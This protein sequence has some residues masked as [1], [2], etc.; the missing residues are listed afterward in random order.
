M[1]DIDDNFEMNENNEQKYQ[2]DNF[3]DMEGSPMSNTE[4]SD[5]VISEI[6]EEVLESEI[7]TDD[8]KI[9]E[10]VIDEPEEMHGG[11]TD[12]FNT[13]EIQSI[14][15]NADNMQELQSEAE[16]I[17]H[18][19]ITDEETQN[20][21]EGFEGIRASEYQKMRERAADKAA[22]KAEKKAKKSGRKNGGKL[23]VKAASFVLCAVLLG[24]ISAGAFMGVIHAT[25][26]DDKLEAAINAADKN[27]E[28]H[29]NSVSVN[30]TIATGTAEGTANVAAIFKNTIPSVVSI[31]SKVVYESQG[32]G[33]FG[34][35]G[36]YESTGAGSG[37]IVSKNDSEL[38]IVTN[39]HVIDNASSLIISFVDGKEAPATV[40]GT[41]EENDLAVVA[42]KLS[43]I[44][45]STLNSISLAAFGDSDTLEV[46]DQ[47]IA[48]GNA[49]GYGQS[50]TVGYV[51]ALSR[52]VTIDGVTRTLLQTDAAINPGNSGGA[53]LN[54][55]GELIG[56]NSAKYSDTDVEGIGFAIPIS[57]VKELIEELMNKEPLVEVDESQASFLGITPANV[58]STSA[59]MY[60]MPVGVYVYELTA[61]GPA[62]QSGLKIRDIITKVDG[63]SV[64]SD[65]ELRQMLKYFAG[66]TTVD[67]TVERAV[68]G[69]YQEITIPVQLGLKSDYE[70]NSASAIR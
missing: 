1:R 58:D 25:G 39:N 13:E 60:N 34:N 42:V 62:E 69:A 37:I 33:F 45:E 64:K 61:G 9:T 68:D 49:L 10:Q 46:G 15:E 21:T 36:T 53:L 19:H 3:A 14:T 2:G 65:E 16:N 50:L 32:F 4:V 12:E 43:D 35:G 47:V 48:I 5:T 66:G 27:N 38:L 31:T 11:N 30:G 67:I 59:Y 44:E 51:S 63:T 57:S 56:I 26:Y 8:E 24:V 6:S 17:S 29:I 40:K 41:S 18:M 20:P 23:L 28:A 55:R 52:D 7:M 70:D 22:K 54:S